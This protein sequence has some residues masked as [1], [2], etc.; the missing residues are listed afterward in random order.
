MS[1]SITSSTPDINKI[2]LDMNHLEF[3]RDYLRYSEMVDYEGL[4][5]KVQ[6]IL[7]S[8]K[9]DFDADKVDTKCY[10]FLNGKQSVNLEDVSNFLTSIDITSIQTPS[11]LDILNY[12]VKTFF[13]QNTFWKF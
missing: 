5:L 8:M 12:K 2:V 11:L 13:S 1:T 3:L 10:F 4:S 9:I 7:K 6:T